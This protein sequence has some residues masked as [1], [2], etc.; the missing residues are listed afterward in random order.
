MT[1]NAHLKELGEFLKARRGELSP[2]TVGLPSTS[3][4]RVPGLR[5]D[6]VAKLAS[7]STGY[8]TRLEQGHIQPSGPILQ[9]LTH[10]LH[11]NDDQRGQLFEL[12]SK[13]SARPRRHRVQKVQPVLQRL[14]DDL[15]FTPAVVMGRR[16]DVLA[17]N[18]LGAAL[19]TDFSRI[20]EKHRNYV[21]ILFTDPAMRTLYADWDCTARLCVAML[22]ME[23]AK[24]PQDARLAALVGELSVQD[25]DFRTWW[26][27]HRAS[28]VTIG[29]K[30]LHHPIAGDLTLHWDTLTVGTASDQ[31]LTVWTAEPGTPSGDGLRLLAS[32]AANNGGNASAT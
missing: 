11:L 16:L 3:P 24:Y 25:D 15:T 10:V 30:A 9:V 28:S 8:Y 13:D 22:R 4:R 32:W 26:G 21:R 12:A 20:P 7:I 1:N 18:A 2:C 31:H 17:W 5:R 19:V 6:E 14:L 27:N 23:A 29:A